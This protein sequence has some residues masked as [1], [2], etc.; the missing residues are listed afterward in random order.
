MRRS[1]NHSALSATSVICCAGQWPVTPPPMKLL[2][3][4]LGSLDEVK[5]V[6]SEFG[7]TR[8]SHCPVGAGGL[9]DGFVG[10]CPARGMASAQAP[11]SAS[12]RLRYARMFIAGAAA[13]AGEADP[14]H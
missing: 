4:P 9:A 13:P 2:Y 5:C 11:N 7:V 12:E 14:A 8:R 6:E 10:C 3:S 1:P